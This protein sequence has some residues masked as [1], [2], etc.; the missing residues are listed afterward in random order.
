MYICHP[1][2]RDLPQAP[3]RLSNQYRYE[4][5][6]GSMRERIREVIRQTR[7]KMGVHIVRGVLAHDHVHMFRSI[8]PELLLSDVM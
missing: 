1:R 5:L 3:R 8:L 2:T 4:V 6:Q 7:D